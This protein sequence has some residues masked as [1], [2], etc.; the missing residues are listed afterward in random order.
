MSSRRPPRRGDAA[1]IARRKNTLIGVVV[2]VVVIA[3]AVGIAMLTAGSEGTVSLA[4]VAGNPSIEG[5]GI[6]QPPEDPSQGDP[7]V[8]SQAPVVTGADFDGNAVTVGEPGTPQLLMFV[9]SWCPLCQEE[10]PEVVSWMEAGGLPDD[11]ELVAVNTLLDPTR[12]NWPPQDWF[13]EENF[14]GQ[15]LVDDRNNNVAEAFGLASTPYWV[16]I[17][18]EGQIASRITGMLD[19]EELDAVADLV[20]AG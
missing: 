12:P 2:G 10:L 11:V 16:A 1:R 20:S 18:A 5:D 4:S 9:A 19:A 3:G 6:G 14:T 13:V 17:D 15:V 8:G 7:D